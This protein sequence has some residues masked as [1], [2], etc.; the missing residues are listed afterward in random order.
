MQACAGADTGADGNTPP[1]ALLQALLLYVPDECSLP[2]TAVQSASQLSPQLDWYLPL[3]GPFPSMHSFEASPGHWPQAPSA[4]HENSTHLWSFEQTRPP[5]Q[6]VVVQ[7]SPEAA[8]QSP[9]THMPAALHWSSHVLL[10]PSAGEVRFQT[11]AAAMRAWCTIYQP[12]KRTEDM[13]T[14]LGGTAGLATSMCKQDT[15]SW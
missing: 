11:C 15:V 4:G 1:P 2:Q 6:P 3:V 14:A 12:R 5:Q 13:Y 7:D 10:L 8:Q 9:P